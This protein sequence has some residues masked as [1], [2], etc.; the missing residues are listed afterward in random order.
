MD[1]YVDNVEDS[2]KNYSAVG[3]MIPKEAQRWVK[4]FSNEQ[5]KQNYIDIGEEN[6]LI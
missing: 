5:F 6:K 4:K 2:F 1:D 3:N